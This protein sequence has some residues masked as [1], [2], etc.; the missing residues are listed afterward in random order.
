LLRICLTIVAQGSLRQLTPPIKRLTQPTVNASK[1]PSHAGLT[2]VRP[3]YPMF[4]FGV[5]FGDFDTVT[6]S[7]AHASTNHKIPCLAQQVMRLGWAVYSFGGGHFASTITSHNL[8]F[9]IKLACDQYESGRAMF[10]E[11]IL[12]TKI[13]NNGNEMS[14]YIR[15]SGDNSH[16]HGPP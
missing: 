5:R 8:P 9:C 13:F 12:R 15:G 16:L 3:I 11:F 14:D 6:P 2:P 10:R 4:P 7:S 1:L